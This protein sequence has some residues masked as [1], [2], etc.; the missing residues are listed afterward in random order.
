[1][2]DTIFQG[3]KV[4]ISELCVE[5]TPTSKL[6]YSAYRSPSRARRRRDKSKVPNLRMPVAY[7]VGLTLH[8]HPLV[9]EKMK[10]AQGGTQ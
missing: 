7:Q 3:M 2:S 8:V 10:D 9:W 6:D 5:D 4:V 1:M